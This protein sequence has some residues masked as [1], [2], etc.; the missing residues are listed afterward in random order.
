[1]YPGMCITHLII[2]I[3]DTS[4]NKEKSSNFTYIDTQTPHED[5]GTQ[6]V[7]ANNYANVLAEFK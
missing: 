2:L 4:Q 1:M 3:I 6:N 5:K 7:V